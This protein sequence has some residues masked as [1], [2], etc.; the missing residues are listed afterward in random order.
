MK[1]PIKS[2]REYCLSC[3]GDSANEVRLCVNPRCKLYPYRLGKRPDAD[4]RYE[5]ALL[6]PIKAIRARCLDCS[7]FIASEVKRC[8][9]PDCVLYP[10]RMGRNPNI[11]E[12][13][14]EKAR[15]RACFFVRTGDVATGFS[16]KGVRAE[17]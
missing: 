12:K 11:S 5:G 4:N 14:R 10:Y 6:T 8:F 2:I 15:Q 3:S 1:T 13:T 9:L 7:G 16:S 17:L